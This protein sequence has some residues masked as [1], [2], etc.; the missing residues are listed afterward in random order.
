MANVARKHPSSV[1]KFDAAP[2]TMLYGSVAKT[3]VANYGNNK[4]SDPQFTI[5]AGIPLDH[6]Q[7]P[8]LKAEFARIA[9]EAFGSAQGVK[10]PIQDGERIADKAKAKNPPKNRERCRGFV[11]LKANSGAEYPPSLFMVQ[12]GGIV[13]IEEDMRTQNAGKFYP[14]VL[15]ALEVTL[16]AYDGNGNTDPADGPVIANGV[17]AYIR[18]VCSTGRGK[19]LSGGGAERYAGFA[20]NVGEVSD[21]NPE[22]DDD[23]GSGIT[24]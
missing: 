24:Y 15:C 14:G 21:E 4:K 18:S 8:A 1:F 13:E 2:V 9:Q 22:D 6:P 19:K 3:Q 7:F 11:V 12:A 5:Q 16:R 10:F 23:A 20:K 17:A